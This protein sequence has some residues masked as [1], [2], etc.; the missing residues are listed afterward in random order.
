[1]KKEARVTKRLTKAGSITVPIKTRQRLGWAHNDLFVVEE[2]E[3][4]NSIILRKVGGVCCITG[5]TEGLMMINNRVVSY[6]ALKELS[7]IYKEI[8]KSI[9]TTYKRGARL[10]YTHYINAFEENYDMMTGFS[11]SPLFSKN[12]VLSSRKER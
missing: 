8:N 11:G 10:S 9:R 1:M 3:S 4:D 2:M 12:K 7:E 6:R 5:E